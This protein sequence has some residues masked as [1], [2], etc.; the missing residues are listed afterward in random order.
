MATP[1]FLNPCLVAGTVVLLAFC[2]TLVSQGVEG[3]INIHLPPGPPSAIK[4]RH[5]GT[6]AR[7][8]TWSICDESRWQSPVICDHEA[9]HKAQCVSAIDLY[10]HRLSRGCLSHTEMDLL[11]MF[12]SRSEQTGRCRVSNGTIYC[13]CEHDMCNDHNLF[14]DHKCFHCGGPGHAMQEC[15]TKNGVIH[16]CLSPF[17]LSLGKKTHG[18][19]YCVKEV[20]TAAGGAVA[21][22]CEA[23]ES[24]PEKMCQYEGNSYKCYCTEDVCNIG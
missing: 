23:L 9:G 11:Y 20:D 16:K 21:R 18:T 1:K 4:C 17:V 8:P 15:K 24:P 14:V 3:Q 10:D 7:K 6:L 22:Y 12:S 5:S 19:I 13:F 2:V